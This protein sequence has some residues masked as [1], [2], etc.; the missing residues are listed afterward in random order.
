[1]TD[2]NIQKQQIDAQTN[3]FWKNIQE[4]YEIFKTNNKELQ[5]TIVDGKYIFR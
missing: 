3:S 4:G 1:M 5:F 2:N